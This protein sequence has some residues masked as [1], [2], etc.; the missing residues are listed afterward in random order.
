VT[1]DKLKE[2]INLGGGFIIALVIIYLLYK[3]LDKYL[4]VVVS[5]HVE[6]QT[7][8]VST[9]QEMHTSLAKMAE[10][11]AGNIREVLIAIKIVSSEVTRLKEEIDEV[12]N[13]RK[14]E[15]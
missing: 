3:L 5:K 14:N 8:M 9:M 1:V 15:A 2:F 11:Q 6:T 10:A 7:T 12:L 13:G 4:A